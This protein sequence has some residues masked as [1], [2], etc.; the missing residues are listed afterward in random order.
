MTS[1]SGERLESRSGA[2]FSTS[3]ANGKSACSM[4]SSTVRRR[5]R[6]SSRKVL[7]LAEPRP[8][9]QR[10]DEIA[11]NLGHLRAAAAGLGHAGQQVAL[12]GVAVEQRQEGGHQ[13]GR[14]GRPLRRRQRPQALGEV[15]GQRHVDRIAAVGLDGGARPVG[16]QGQDGARLGELLAPVG[17]QPLALRT[18][19]QV[20]L[21]VDEVR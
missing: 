14:E 10:V 19:E 6:S 16:G 2:S 7:P 3:S 4:A 20:A 1:N 8:D 11:D 12:V 9:H 17:P 21:P 18:G 5:L 13:G 15:A